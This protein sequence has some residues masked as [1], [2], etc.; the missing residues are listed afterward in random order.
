[1]VLQVSGERGARRSN[2]LEMSLALGMRPLLVDSQHLSRARR[3]RMFWLSVDLMDHEEV[4]IYQRELY[5]EVIFGAAT[6]PMQAILDEGWEWEPGRR[7]T[8]KRFPI[9]TRAIKR[10]KPP[11]EPAGLASTDE[12]GK[13]DSAGGNITSGTPLIHM[14]HIT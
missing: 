10:Q 9:F 6:E 5:D 13:P 14:G 1:M 11:K 7:D 12:T 4:E 3:P 2:L 8:G